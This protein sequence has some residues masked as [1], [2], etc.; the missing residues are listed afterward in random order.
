MNNVDG[1][2]KKEILQS[3]V[4]LLQKSF[5]PSRSGFMPISLN[6]HQSTSTESQIEWKTN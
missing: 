1:Q 3:F 4:A 5:T 2:E 6:E